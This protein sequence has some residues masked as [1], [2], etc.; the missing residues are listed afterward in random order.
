MPYDMA[1][2]P[3]FPK[4]LTAGALYEALRAA[5]AANG[6]ALPIHAD[7]EGLVWAGRTMLN[8]C[9]DL[10]VEPKIDVVDD[11]YAAAV[12]ELATRDLSVLETAD[13]VAAVQA[14]MSAKFALTEAKWS[15]EVS[16]WF[17]CHLGKERGFSPRQVEKYLR[18]ARATPEQRGR[19]AGARSLHAAV[20]RLEVPGQRRASTNTRSASLDELLTEL[21]CALDTNMSFPPETMTLL[22]GVR[23]LIDE[24][25][26]AGDVRS[27]PPVDHGVNSSAN[28]E[29]EQPTSSL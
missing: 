12:A 25:L 20:G 18:V 4:P 16:S 5:T 17:R 1:I 6:Q 28:A 2:L 7:R 21:V 14:D 29:H 22:Q 8:I 9:F 19:M 26:A 23:S 3:G 13:L 11:G 27:Q 15:Q 10:G 24:I